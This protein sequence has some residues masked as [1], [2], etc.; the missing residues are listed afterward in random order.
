MATIVATILPFMR[1]WKPGTGWF[2]IT[3]FERAGDGGFVLELAVI[4]AALVWIDAAW[5]SRIVILVAGPAVL[6]GTCLVI[7]RDFYQTGVDYLGGLGGSGGHGGF[8]PGF[9][10]TIAAASALLITGALTTWRA[11]DRLSFRPGATVA[12]FAGFAGGLIGAIAGFVAGSTITPLFV[13]ETVGQTSTVLVIVA[14]GL[15]FLGAWFGALLGSSV[16]RG[17]RRP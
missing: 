2:E 10:L 9:W 7:L 1:V 12:S 15:A 3:G 16:A 14:A 5:N 6:G 11:R 17:L 4:A 13:H 8:E